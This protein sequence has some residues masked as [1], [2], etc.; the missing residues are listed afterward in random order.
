MVQYKPSYC[1]KVKCTP[2]VLSNSWEVELNTE[3]ICKVKHTLS[4]L[5]TDSYFLCD[6]LFFTVKTGVSVFLSLHYIL[7]RIYIVR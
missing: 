5:V 2:S 1:R 6:S 7:V 3:F 4:F